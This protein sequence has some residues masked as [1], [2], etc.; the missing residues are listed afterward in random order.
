MPNLDDLPPFRRAKLLWEFAH[1]GVLGVEAL[2]READACWV[3]RR[4][5][6]RPQAVP[7]D[8]GLVHLAAPDGLV[9]APHY[10]T[11]EPKVFDGA[12]ALADV[13]REQQ[14]RQYGRCSALHYWPPPPARTAVVRRLRAALVGALGPD[15]HLCGRYAGAMVDHDHETGLVRGLLCP[16]CNR[17][18][19]QC[20]H[21]D[22]CPKADYMA[23]PPAAHLR[24]VY[25]K[26]LEWKPTGAR[27]EQVIGFLGF[28][29]FE[30]L[31]RERGQ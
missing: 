4:D 22:G 27:R 18:L 31:R 5:S 28:D 1:L 26:Y 30:E 24:L 21:L 12:V 6:P 11:R 23:R 8:D 29:P 3:E 7:G 14:C 2:V 17:S 10:G 25:P 16:L 13:P 15:C 19:E 20:P 9:C